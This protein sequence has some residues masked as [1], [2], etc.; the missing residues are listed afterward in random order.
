MSEKMSRDYY[1]VLGVPREAGMDEIKKAYRKLAMKYHPDRNPGDGEAEAKFKEAAEAYEVLSDVQ[2]RRIYDAYG[3]QGLKNTGYR[4]PGT[5]DD[6]FSSIND[7]FGDLFGFGGRSRQRNPNGP[8][9]GDDL[10]YDMEISFMDAVHGVTREVELTKRET[11]WTCEGSGLR[12]GYKPQMCPTC[13]GRGQVIRSQGF[14]QVSSTCPQCGGSGQII[15]DPCNDCHGQGLVNKTKRVSIKIPAGVDTGARM[16]LRG[17][18]EGGRRGGPSGDLYVVIYVRPHEYFQR[19]GQNIYLRYPVSMVKAA[20]GC[21]VEVPTIHGSA[22]LKIPAGTQPGEHF[23][24]KHQGVAG[25][26]GKSPG[27][28]I[29]EVQVQTP[30]KLTKQ[31]KTLLREFAEQSSESQEEGFFSRLFHS[32]FSQTDKKQHAGDA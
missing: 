6:I 26:R 12:P 22:K 2:K 14:F 15:T 18:G 24:L 27:D 3:H 1:E 20:L 17:E 32:H 31:Q 30:T 29:V 25:L 9:P 28:M 11:C 4:G 5:A 13:H 10:R 7:L 21:E 16:R 23:T 19:E 8:I